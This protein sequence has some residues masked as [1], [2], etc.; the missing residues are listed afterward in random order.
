MRIQFT[1]I[2][3]CE[4]AV[5]TD[6][7]DISMMRP[8]SELRFLIEKIGSLREKNFIYTFF[9]ERAEFL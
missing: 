4:N 1:S 5:L 8:Q 2:F 9:T 7:N 6:R 3:R